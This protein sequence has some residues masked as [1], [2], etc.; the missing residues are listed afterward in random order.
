MRRALWLLALL[1]SLLAMAS[2]PWERGVL[3]EVGAYP[4]VKLGIER[5]DGEVLAIR[6][7]EPGKGLDRAAVNTLRRQL[8]QRVRYRAAAYASSPVYG[9]EVI[10]SQAESDR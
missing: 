3:V 4:L 10:L 5:S 1:P 6:A 8:G 9:R 2:P 7:A